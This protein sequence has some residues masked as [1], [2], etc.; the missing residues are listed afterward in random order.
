MLTWVVDTDDA[1]A[2][3]SDVANEEGRA[4]ESDAPNRTTSDTPDVK[5]KD[6]EAA[7]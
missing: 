4:A 3:V 7:V 6:L 1:G 5:E 2:A